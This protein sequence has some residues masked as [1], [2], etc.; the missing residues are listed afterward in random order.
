MHYKT[1]SSLNWWFF[2][3]YLELLVSYGTAY[4]LFV[5]TNIKA[6]LIRFFVI[7]S[8]FQSLLAL[9]QFLIQRS[10]GSIFHKLGE[11][12][13]SPKMQGIA[14]IVSGGTEFIRGY[15]TF[16]HPNVLSA[17][18]VVGVILSIYLL[19]EGKSYIGKILSA[20][21]VLINLLGVTVTFSRA[22]FLGLAV[23]LTIFFGWLLIK[24]YKQEKGR[25]ILKVC[26]FTL[27]AAL[28]CFFAFRPFLDTRAT[29]SDDASLE[30]IFY[31]KIGLKMIARYPIFGVGIGESVLHMQQYLPA[32]NFSDKI[33]LLKVQAGG[34]NALYQQNLQKFMAGE[35]LKLWP[36]QIQPVHNYFLLA[37][38][39]VG[40][41]GMIIFAWIFLQHLWLLIEKLK[42]QSSIGISTWDLSL[43][44]I[45]TA[46]LLLMQFD[47][48]FYTLQQTQM[49]LW[50]I[51]GII[52]AQIK[53][54][55]Q[56]D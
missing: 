29:I 4:Y 35:P 52:A 34:N 27:A 45:L 54:P 19:I 5:K 49:L 51:L 41:P 1:L 37:A 13:L 28:L 42:Y 10:I 6:L 20:L 38:A 53:N 12:V 9:W 40:I 7:L 18:L 43:V 36:W 55:Q 31:A 39:E 24:P 21:S 17:F 16:P 8:N 56:G 3:K 47:H 2:A 26:L 48:Y 22:G 46:F 32:L 11:Q 25:L 50:V 23:A 14:K 15:G 44:A 30:R 33:Q